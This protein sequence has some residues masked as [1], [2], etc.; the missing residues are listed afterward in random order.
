MTPTQGR[1]RIVIADDHPLYRAS[2]VRAI[3]HHPSIEVVAEAADGRTALEEIRRLEPEVALVDMH[4]PVLDGAAVINAV[5]R[6]N[7]PTRV[8]LLSGMLSD[9]QIYEA[10]EQGAAAILTKTVEAPEVLDAVQAVARGEVVLA[11]ELQAVVASQIRVRAREQRPLLTQREQE[12][13]ACM[14]QGMPGPEIA[15]K[16]SVSP[17]T[18]KS[19]TEKLYEKLG[20]TDRGAAVAEG[21]RQGLIE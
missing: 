18:V 10:L 15:R 19:H 8:M 3:S 5:A 13:L 21:M 6:D 14:A 4:M 7:L 20:V 11:P 9:Q 16:L 2:V 1:V 17:S 12:I